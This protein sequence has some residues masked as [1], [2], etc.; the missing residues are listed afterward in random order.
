VS[1]HERSLR[2]GEGGRGFAMVT[3]PEHDRSAPIV[4][5]LNAGLL[6]RA[7]PYRLNVLTARR[8]AALGYLCV[9][10]D[11]SGKGDTPARE[12]LSNRESVALDWRLV[13]EALDHAFGR[14]PTIIMGLCSGADNG[15][16]LSAIDQRVHGLVLLDAQTPRDRGFLARRLLSKALDWHSWARLPERLFGRRKPARRGQASPPTNLRDLPRPED[17]ATCIRHLVDKDGRLLML[18]TSS[19]SRYYNREGQFARA[20]A[21]PGLRK[22]CKEHYWPDVEH[23]YPVQAHRDRL[24]DTI[25][26]WATEHLEHFRTSPP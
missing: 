25:E 14:R 21:T 19:A 3:L 9:R 26:A 16:K 15:I 22:I 1:I 6:H 20:Y 17:L 4:V 18:F 23:L 24:V 13:C 7:E 12:G 8:L 2:Y 10:M 5:L 11:L